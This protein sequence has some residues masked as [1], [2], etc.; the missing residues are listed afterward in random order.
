MPDY[1]VRLR[2]TRRNEMVEFL[3]CYECDMLA[4]VHQG[5]RNEGDFDPKHNELVKAIQM[6]F[7]RDK[8][9]RKLRLYE[10]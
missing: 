6:V 10:R 2:F 7:P 9:V 3:L 4:V 8:V 5:Q 1:G